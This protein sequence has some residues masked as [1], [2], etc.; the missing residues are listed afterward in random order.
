MR[1]LKSRPDESDT[2][3]KNNRRSTLINHQLEKCYERYLMDEI[4][5]EFSKFSNE[6]DGFQINTI[7]LT[8]QFKII[9]SGADRNC[10]F[11]IIN[12]II[13]GGKLIAKT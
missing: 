13:F 6:S 3:I 1:T 12:N 8:S 11:H 4:T 9:P 7:E 10:L 2:L 5:D